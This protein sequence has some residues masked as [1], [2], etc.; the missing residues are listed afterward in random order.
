[1]VR[2]LRAAADQSERRVLY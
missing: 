1:M 2:T